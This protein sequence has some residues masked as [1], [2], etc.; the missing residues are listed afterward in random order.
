MVWRRATHPSVTTLTPPRAAVRGLR[1]R[2]RVDAEEQR[3]VPANGLTT[4]SGSIGCSAGSGVIMATS[5]GTRQGFACRVSTACS[6]VVGSLDKHRDTATLRIVLRP[7]SW[8]PHPSHTPLP[9][10]AALH[11]VGGN[12]PTAA[13]CHTNTALRRKAAFRTLQATQPD[14]ASRSH[15]GE[16]HLHCA[17]RQR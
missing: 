10:A 4:F 13:R 7:T 2:V 1:Q 9:R 16:G 12:D 6:P 3:A 15:C 14:R 8:A 17:V 11:Q 5:Q